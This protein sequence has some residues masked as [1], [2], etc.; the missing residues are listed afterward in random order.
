M[1]TFRLLETVIT[2]QIAGVPFNIPNTESTAKA[3]EILVDSD[4]PSEAIWEFIE[5]CKNSEIAQD[6]EYLYFK[7]LTKEYFLKLDGIRFEQPIPQNLVDLI[8]ESFEKSIDYLP[9]IKALARLLNNPRYTTEMANYFYGYLTST[10]TD[11]DAVKEMIDEQG[12]TAEAAE[13]ACTYPDISI[14]KEGLLA[15]FQK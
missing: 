13:K 8:V 1:I 15:T 11:E 2:G 5:D 4:A 14:T 7:P 3:L 10:Y 6:C 12:Y 9:V